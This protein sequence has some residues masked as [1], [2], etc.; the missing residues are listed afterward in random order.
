[1][2]TEDFLAIGATLTPQ[3][4]TNNMERMKK[5][6]F[7]AS[8]IFVIFHSES[9][10]SQHIKIVDSININEKYKRVSASD[11]I[12]I[13]TY[14]DNCVGCIENKITLFY[15]NGELNV[16]FEDSLTTSL[17]IVGEVAPTDSIK[18]FSLIKKTNNH[19]NLK[20][21]DYTL[22]SNLIS[23][24]VLA[25]VQKPLKEKTSV[26][27]VDF[28]SL[29]VEI[30]K[31]ENLVKESTLDETKEVK[32]KQLLFDITNQDAISYF[33]NIDAKEYILKVVLS[34]W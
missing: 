9:I 33:S 15:K 19:E 21:A 30:E 26:Y 16:V 6:V 1:M 17:Q 13:V 28:S 8:L 31:M 22:I 14:E 5:T 27:S 7:I 18:L 12:K 3:D 25:F 10:Y 4:H 32:S 34:G 23:E 29:I 20:D 24:G 2:Q 11:T